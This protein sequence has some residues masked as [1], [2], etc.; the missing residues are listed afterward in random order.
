MKTETAKKSFLSNS[1]GDALTEVL[2]V[3]VAVAIAVG[4]LVTRLRPG[5]GE[6]QAIPA[7]VAGAVMTA[8]DNLGKLKDF[9]LDADESVIFTKK[10]ACKSN[11]RIVNMSVELWHIER[12]SW[13]N[14]DLS[15]MGRDR[16]YFPN[17][18]PKCPLNNT[19]YR[20]DPFLHR[21]AGH[22][23]TEIQN[24]FAAGSGEKNI[25]DD[26][27]PKKNKKSRK[28]KSKSKELQ[29]TMNLE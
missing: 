23:H 11:V 16:N 20:L 19:P 18:I 1:R 13:P 21:V 5:G 28:N 24:P 22:E 3:T 9:A 25:L 8:P 7:D 4:I 6:A 26:K 2:A 15:D 17:G 27:K 29:D 12:G 10:A 14:E